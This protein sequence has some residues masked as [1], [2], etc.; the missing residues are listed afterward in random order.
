MTRYQASPKGQ[1]GPYDLFGAARAVFAL[2]K[3][4][5]RRWA[6]R[7]AVRDLLDWDDNALRDI[8]LTRAD[9]RLALGLPMS[10]DPSVRLTDWVSERRTAYQLSRRGQDVADERPYPRLVSGASR[11]ISASSSRP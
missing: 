5:A 7:R 6:N 1:S 9:V 10:E 4:V 2:L 8:G 11:S 3:F